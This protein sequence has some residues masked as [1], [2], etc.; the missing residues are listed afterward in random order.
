MKII[1]FKKQLYQN[2]AFVKSG[3]SKMFFSMDDATREK[4]I[5]D[6][7]LRFENAI[8]CQDAIEAS[9]LASMLAQLEVD[10]VVNG[11]PQTERDIRFVD[12]F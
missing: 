4:R 3:L 6:L 10:I 8:N 1:F 5:K 9:N 7:V 12:S 11:T 2:A